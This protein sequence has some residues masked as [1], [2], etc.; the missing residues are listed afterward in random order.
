MTVWMTKVW[1][2]GEP[3]GPLQFS[4]EGWRARA[5]SQLQRG[6]VVVLVGTKGGETQEGER[7][8]LLGR[9]SRRPSP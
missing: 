3:V 1:G 9:W 7:G 8:L 2:F 4:T 5:R 6:D